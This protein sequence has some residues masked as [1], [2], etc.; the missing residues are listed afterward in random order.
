MRPNRDVA[1]WRDRR[2]PSQPWVGP[3]PSPAALSTPL[4]A[5]AW[6]GSSPARSTRRAGRPGRDRSLLAPP[7]RGPAP[8]RRVVQAHPRRRRGRPPA[9]AIHV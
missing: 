2:L 4:S 1:R 9:Q 6:G 5:S 3:H 7:L 8:H